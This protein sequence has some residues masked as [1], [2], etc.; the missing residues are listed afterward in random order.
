MSSQIN[1]DGL[2]KG[3][4]WV[5]VQLLLKL[6]PLSVIF[7]YIFTERWWKRLCSLATP[8]SVLKTPVAEGLCDVLLL[9]LCILMMMMTTLMCGIYF[10][11]ISWT[12]TLSFVNVSH[13]CSI[14]IL[15][16]CSNLFK[17]PDMLWSYKYVPLG[18]EC[19]AIWWDSA[20]W[21]PFSNRRIQQWNK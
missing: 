6:L 14:I 19:V 7:Y 13:H 11:S 16:N 9:L 18:L 20:A 1:I 8:F 12:A 17:G 15:H 21:Q 4:A 10:H 5:N 2:C 3:F